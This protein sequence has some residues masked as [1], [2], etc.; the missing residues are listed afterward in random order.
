MVTDLILR[1]TGKFGNKGERYEVF[2]GDEIIAQGW[3]PEHA[4]CRVLLARGIEGIARFSRPGKK[5][6]DFTM[7][8]AKASTRNVLEN[9]KLGPRTVKWEP[10]DRFANKDEDGEI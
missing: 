6:H 4:A 3:S 10:N 1:P 7:N 8:I 2:L 9:A 5:H